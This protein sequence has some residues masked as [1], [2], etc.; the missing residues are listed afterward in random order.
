MRFLLSLLTFFLVFANASAM[1]EMDIMPMTENRHVEIRLFANT[2]DVKPGDTVTIGIEQ[3]ITPHWHTYWINPGDSGEPTRAVWSGL[4]GLKTSPIRWPAPEK[5]SIGP[6]TNYGYEDKVVLLQDITLPDT[7]PQGEF[8]LNADISLL[9][10]EEIC[11]P[12]FGSY[13][14]TFNDKSLGDSVG[15]DTARS[16][17]LLTNRRRHSF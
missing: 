1:A 2:K 10:C 16:S 14:I 12:E 13:S 15:I 17:T 7:L 3:V 6:L 5:I 4:E 9:V 8:T 11:I